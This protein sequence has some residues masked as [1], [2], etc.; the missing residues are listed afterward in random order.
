MPAKK[1]GRISQAGHN[2]SRYEFG[3]ALDDCK[4]AFHILKNNV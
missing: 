1:I 3:A 2:M 4:A